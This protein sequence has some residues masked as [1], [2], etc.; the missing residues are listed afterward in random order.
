VS[1][2]GALWLTG[3]GSV[4]L[5]AAL[6]L[7]DR[8]MQH[9]GGHGIVSFELAGSVER[10]EQILRDWGP[11]G[12]DAARLSLWV[13]YPYIVAYGAFL[14]L[15]ARALRDGLRRRGWVRLARPGGIVALLAAVG[16]AC[17]AL[18]DLF[19]LRILGGAR[20]A[21]PALATGFATV[22]FACLAVAYL[23]VLVGL[24]ALGVARRR[25]AEARA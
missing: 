10:A 12:R 23:Y 2:R 14:W 13:D 11:D 17:D 24:V 9:A 7:I 4:G 15:A 25:A 3:I 21:A 16:A 8:R 20:G 5:F 22:K 6:A 1:R 19:L 18:E